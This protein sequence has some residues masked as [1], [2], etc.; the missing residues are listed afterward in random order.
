MYTVIL[1][2]ISVVIGEYFV[3]KN[4]NNKEYCE[5]Y[6]GGGNRHMGCNRTILLHYL[7]MEFKSKQ[8]IIS[9]DQKQNHTGERLPEGLRS[10]IKQMLSEGKSQRQIQSETGVSAH[11][12]VGIR[13][14]MPALD[15]KSWKKNVMETLRD[16]VSRGASRLSDEIDDIPITAMPVSLGILIDKI[17]V[18]NDQ[19]TAV[20]EHRMRITHDEINNILLD[21]NVIDEKP[22]TESCKS[23][24]LAENSHEQRQDIQQQEGT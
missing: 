15:E 8:E 16:V 6:S 9:N 14:S 11:T 2:I 3:N 4:R 21:A 5:R 13:K 12:I 18:L 7:H 23:G 20:V 22:L 19:P 24:S 10:Q 1:F 17:N